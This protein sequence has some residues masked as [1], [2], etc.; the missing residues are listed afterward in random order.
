MKGYRVKAYD[1]AGAFAFGA[2]IWCVDDEAAFDKFSSL[3]I[4]EHRAE[5]IRGERRLA[6]RDARAELQARAS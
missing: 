1:A 4:G 6:Q 2:T 3:P 5:L